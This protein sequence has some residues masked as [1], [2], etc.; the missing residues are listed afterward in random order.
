MTA[1]SKADFIFR[2]KIPFAAITLISFFVMALL[3]SSV[4]SPSS[5]SIGP[6]N[7][8]GASGSYCTSCHTSYAL[9]SGGGSVTLTGMPASVFD[10]SQTYNFSLNIN[11]PVADRNRWGFAIKA[12][13]LAGASIGTFSSSNNNATVSGSELV[14][15]NAP[16]TASQSSYSFSGLSWTAPSSTSGDNS[17]VKFYFVGN[18]AL[19]NFSSSLD[20]IYSNTLTLTAGTP[21]ACDTAYWTGSL[22]TAWE[23]A[24]NWSCGAVPNSNTV[25]YI[26]STAIR[27]PVISS[28]AACKKIFTALGSSLTVNTGY[29]LNVSGTDP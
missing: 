13:N 3:T 29:A 28:P 4:F 8:T 22:N 18:A 7:Y 17:S 15:F 12:V 16:G 14:H 5:S 11:H 19:S 1:R 6:Q 10:A 9:N 23:T 25:V 24:G 27:F 26:N 20:Y 2:N 21:P